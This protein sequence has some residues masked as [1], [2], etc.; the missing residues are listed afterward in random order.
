MKSL[1]TLSLLAVLVLAGC[2]DALTEAEPEASLEAASGTY[3]YAAEYE[4]VVRNITKGQPFTPPLA[5]THNGHVDMFTVGHKASFGIKEI[6]ENGN[7]APLV[8]YLSA[9]NNVSDVV[10]AVAGDPPPVMPGNEVR[11]NISAKHGSKYISFASMLICTNDG[12]TGIDAAMLPRNVGEYSHFNLNAYDAGTEINTED[13]A[14]IVPPCQG[15]VGISSDDD[16][17]GESNPALAENGYI[18]RHGGVKGGND[19]VPGVH[20]WKNPVAKVRV[21]RVR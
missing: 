16:G 4:V 2:S 3:G 6:A 5:A 10:V 12:F 14:D 21:R 8:D 13:F 1:L 19:L 7:L 20:G 17:T 15:L 18:T 9:S 11:F